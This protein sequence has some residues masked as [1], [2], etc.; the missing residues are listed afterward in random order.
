[1]EAELGR[2][3]KEESQTVLLERWRKKVFESLMQSKRYELLIKDNLRRHQ[4]E[5]SQLVNRLE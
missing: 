4:T 1:M 2:G 5:T 3:K